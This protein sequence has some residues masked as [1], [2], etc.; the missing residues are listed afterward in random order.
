[1][2]LLPKI[3]ITNENVIEVIIWF[4]SIVVFFILAFFLF[5]L[6]GCRSGWYGW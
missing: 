2:W 5:W 4:S 3:G 1:M 6:L